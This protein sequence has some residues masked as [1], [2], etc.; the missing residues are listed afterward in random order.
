MLIEVPY[1][2]TSAIEYAKEWALKRNPA[3]LDFEKLGG[4]CTNFAS[5]C[6]FAGSH[7]MNDT[8]VLGWYYYSSRD[9]SASWSGVQFLYNFLMSNKAEGPYA[10]E[11]DR[12]SLEVGD[13]IQLGRHYNDYYHS[14]VVTEITKQ[15]ILVCAHSFDAYLRPLS[16]YEYENIRFLHIQG[17]RKYQ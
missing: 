13:I 16:S 14:P 9:R 10:V 17:V 3:Y 2:R 1:D 8:P 11:T 12:A 5:Q 6:I 4:D 7:V 15:D